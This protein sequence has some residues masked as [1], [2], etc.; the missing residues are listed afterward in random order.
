VSR[1][2]G[3][4]SDSHV[5]ATTVSVGVMLSIIPLCLD[6]GHLT[7]CASAPH[8]HPSFALHGSS[9]FRAKKINFIFISPS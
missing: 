2:L 1:V 9:F 6:D 3:A 8:H 7:I 5:S 4:S